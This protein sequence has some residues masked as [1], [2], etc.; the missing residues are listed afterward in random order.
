[1]KLSTRCRYGTRALTQIARNHGSGPT[2]RKDIARDHELSKGY[3]EN[4]LSALRTRRIVKAVR[5]ADGGFVL[6]R[7]PSQ[8]TL[9][10]VAEALEGTIAPVECVV[11][12]A[13]CERSSS[14][15]AR[16]VWKRLY[17]AQVGV[18]S[19]ITLRDMVEMEKEEQPMDWSI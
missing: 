8:I 1:M 18:L 14:C 5:G 4:I 17:D 11:D 15:A 13:R 12:P 3:L 9:L 2:K 6:G 10:E 19:G 7:D 16:R